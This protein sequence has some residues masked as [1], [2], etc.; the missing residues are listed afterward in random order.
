MAAE[1]GHG[2]DDPDPAIDG[3]RRKKLDTMANYEE[4]LEYLRAKLKGAELRE[5]LAK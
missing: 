2:W 5:R 4:K 1:D 3:I